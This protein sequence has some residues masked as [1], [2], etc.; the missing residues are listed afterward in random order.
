M[1]R[2]VQKFG[3]TSVADIDRLRHVAKQVKQA[4]DDQQVVVVLSAMAG[5]TDRL[6]ALAKSASSHP[7]PR[8]YDSLLSTGEHTTVTLL[9]ML[10]NDAG[11]P[12]KSL[13]AWQMGFRTNRVHKNA[14]ILDIDTKQLDKVLAE[15]IVPIVTG[16]QGVNDLNDITTLGRGGSDVSAVAIAAALNADECQIFTDVD[17]V[18]SAD[19]R[20]VTCAQ[21]LKQITAD[22]MLELASLGAKV[23]Q[24]RA[25]KFAS[26]YHVPLRVLSSFNQG[27]GT[28]ITDQNEVMEKPV[29]S[30]IAHQRDEASLTISGIPRGTGM[31]AKVMTPIA[32]ANINIDMLLQ[33]VDAGGETFTITFTVHRDDFD[34]AEQLL[35]KASYEIGA[36]EV[37]GNNEVSKVSLVGI[38]IRCNPEVTVKVFNTLALYKIPIELTTTSE[39]KI[40]VVIDQ[41]YLELAIRSLHT[42]FGL[43][44]VYYQEETE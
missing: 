21:K 36:A 34:Q 4:S 32:D 16:F 28:L 39:I 40:S 17:G 25:V 31:L 22:E 2:I 26:K 24:N 11:C 9:S 15:G 20:V 5:E 6:I 1:K 13:T 8:E 7:T 33:N 42:A 23:L 27:S 44:S 19:P 38:G 41:S 10:L 43:D 18:Y 29:I 37:I 35:K 30:G 12:A 14:S 3:G